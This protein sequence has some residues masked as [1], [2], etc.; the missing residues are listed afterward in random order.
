MAE[1]VSGAKPISRPVAR[2]GRWR[3]RTKFLVRELAPLL[4]TLLF[5]FPFLV[6]LSTS[7]KPDTESFSIPPRLWS[8]NWIIDNY[9][10]VFDAMPFWRY[11]RN[12][13]FLSVMAVI[14]TLLS[15]PLVAYSLAKIRWRGRNVL[16]ILILSTMMLPP[17]VTMIPIFIMWNKTPFMGTYWPLIVPNFLGTAF[18]IFLL[19][20]FFLTIPRELEDAARI[21]GAGT[22]R[23]FTR[24]VL[25]LSQPVLAALGIF[26]FRSAWNDF[27][28]PLIAVNKPDMF[29]LPVALALLRGAYASES[30]G[31][32]MAGATLSALPLL[33]VF[34][35]ANRRIV[36]GVRVSGLKG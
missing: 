29:P 17:Q 12:T 9:Q 26:A 19:R 16:F 2:A 3:K 1:V 28:W 8:D 33:L 22:W 21:D 14:G 6:M 5:V 32:I 7:F 13:L 11:L 20:Q 15:C 24:I 4:V 23:V 27:L 35:V 10:R 25:P 30:Y 36:E 34:L 31:P 18:F